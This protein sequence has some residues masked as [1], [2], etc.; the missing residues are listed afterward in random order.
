[1]RLVLGLSILFSVISAK[2]FDDSEVH[3]QVRD[4]QVR[5]LLAAQKNMT[6]VSDE[7]LPAGTRIRIAPG[8]M[9]NSSYQSI[10]SGAGQDTF[11]RVIEVISATGRNAEALNDLK[12]ISKNSGLFIRK[13]AEAKLFNQTPPSGP[14]VSISAESAATELVL[15]GAIDL[16]RLENLD[17][18]STRL[19][20]SAADLVTRASSERARY[21]ETNEI[22]QTP[23]ALK[24]PMDDI[25][26]RTQA[27]PTPEPIP[28]PTPPPVPLPA[29]DW[30]GIKNRFEKTWLSLGVPRKALD[31]TF[32]FLIKNPDLP[33]N[34]NYFGIV[35]FSRKSSS[36]RLF[37]ININT[38]AIERNFV[39][40]GSGVR[41]Q[42]PALQTTEFSNEHDSWLTPK[43]FHMTGFRY[44]S[45]D[46][47][48]K[49]WGGFGLRLIGL[50]AG[51][52]DNTLNRGVVIH[53]SKK[54]TQSF[55]EDNGFTG[56]SQGCPMTDRNDAQRFVRLLEI[57]ALWYHYSGA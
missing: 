1:M 25:F 23:D 35:D 24:Q 15:L 49:S 55:V 17:S 2:A 22:N 57:G 44:R 14:Q 21:E 45:T 41:K 50:E 31:Q 39:G 53:G 56:L 54:A 10:F 36:Q 8:S 30:A 28:V 19:N 7:T 47:K 9:I 27:Q 40:H 18:D 20:T 12:I 32:D 34:R 48:W 13:S 52:N 37:L 11:A 26:A 4:N 46:E 42:V 29:T 5:T 33:L 43:G 51:K 6:M 3:F 38:G 16:Y